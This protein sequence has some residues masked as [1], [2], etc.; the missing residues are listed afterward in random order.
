MSHAYVAVQWTRRKVVYD[1]FLV[2]GIAAYYFAFTHFA[3]GASVTKEILEMRAWGTCAFFLLTLILCIGPLAR[4]ST[5][6]A[7]LLYNR[8]H[9]GVL[10]FGVAAMHARAVLGYYYAY[11]G[12]LYEPIAFLVTDAEITGASLPFPLFGGLALFWLMV[13]AVTSHDF[14]QKVL[15]G[16]VWKSLHMGV[17]VA[18]SLVVL[19]VAFGAMRSETHPFY[20]GV[21][22][23]AVLLVGGLHLWTGFR[24][25]CPSPRPCRSQSGL[26]SPQSR[27]APSGGS[28]RSLSAAKAAAFR[29]GACDETEPTWVELDGER[30][31]D[32]GD[33]ERIPEGR[34]I[35]VCVPGQERIALVRWEGQ[36]SALHGLCAHQRGPLYEGKVIA[37]SLTCPWHGWQYR[38]ADGQSPPPF[39]EKLPTHR[40]RMHQGR[41]LVLPEALPPGTATEP[42]VFDVAAAELARKQREREETQ[43]AH[44]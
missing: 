35:P 30:W 23:G 40:V 39:Q 18:W 2:A 14:W 5:R 24:G 28:L 27:S 3:E 36:V 41:V 21:V 32:A 25:S 8:R 19:H 43:D 4:L 33:P 7:P 17:Y 42:A 1:L 37:G 15:G 10:M 9:F 22:L 16:A 26:R 13:M 38:P 34:A 12:D 31:I 44:A 29:S 20:F 6:F 11:T